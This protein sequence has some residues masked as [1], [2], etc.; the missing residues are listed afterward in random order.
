MNAEEIRREAI[1][2]LAIAEWESN[3]AGER[4]VFGWTWDNIADGMR[5]TYR[6]HAGRLVRA[7]GDLLRAEPDAYVVFSKREPDEETWLSGPWD[8]DATVFAD[9]EA[10][11]GSMVNWE[12]E[13]V[14]CGHDPDI[15]AIGEVRLER[16]SALTH[17][18]M[19][20]TRVKL[21]PEQVAES[22]EYVDRILNQE[23]P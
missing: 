15:F 8:T 23:K 16:G 21:T 2:R 9:Y 4:A 7:L 19:H 13:L 18:T 11:V 5:D 12:A 14:N 1:E 22:R 6:L 17:G 20:V 3:H 10:A